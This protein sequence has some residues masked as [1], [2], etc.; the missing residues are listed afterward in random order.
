[1][2]KTLKTNLY[3]ALVLAVAYAAYRWFVLI[4]Q[5]ERAADVWEDGVDEILHVA[6]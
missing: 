5:A 1:M 6:G 2:F 4:G 3:A